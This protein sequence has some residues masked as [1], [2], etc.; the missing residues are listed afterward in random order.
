MGKDWAAVGD[1]ISTRLEQLDMTQDELAKRS[2]V[3]TATVRQIQHGVIPKRRRSP[4]TLSDMSEAL[5]WSPD[6]LERVADGQ[7]VGEDTD[8]FARLESAVSALT[9]RVAALERGTR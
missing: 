8:R 5:G 6:H 7:P 1:A 4:R 3:S 9:E 2:R